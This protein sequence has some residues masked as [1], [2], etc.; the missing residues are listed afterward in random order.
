[1]ELLH[2]LN[3]FEK[4]TEITPLKD[5]IPIL[6][7]SH[8]V[9]IPLLEELCLIPLTGVDMDNS[10]FFSNLFSSL[11]LYISCTIFIK[12]DSDDCLTIE[13]LQ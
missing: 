6:F 4:L 13:K 8:I 10:E 3:P 11:K 12:M 1:M 9:S 7:Q 5:L 2:R